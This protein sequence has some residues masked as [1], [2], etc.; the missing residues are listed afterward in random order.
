MRNQHSASVLPQTSLDV[1]SQMIRTD[2]DE[3][4]LLLSPV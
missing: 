3:V 2:T 4:A 1:L